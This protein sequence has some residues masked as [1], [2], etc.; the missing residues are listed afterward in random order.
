[1]L[2]LPA[3]KNKKLNDAQTPFLRGMNMV[4]KPLTI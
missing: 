2:P 1:M 4:T 3:L